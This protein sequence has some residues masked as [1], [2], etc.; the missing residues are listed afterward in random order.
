[1][2]SAIWSTFENIFQTILP[3]KLNTVLN[4]VLLCKKTVF[5]TDLLTILV[6]VI[7]YPN[8]LTRAKVALGVTN[9]KQ[10]LKRTQKKYIT[11]QRKYKYFTSPKLC[12]PNFKN[13]FY[14][15]TFLITKSI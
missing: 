15:K 13:R 1:M 9:P 10:A 4:T 6:K 8:P 14:K 11:E 7:P 12:S 3:P 2:R 5:N